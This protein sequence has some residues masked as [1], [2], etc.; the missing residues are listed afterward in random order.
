MV[1]DGARGHDRAGH[2]SAWRGRGG[3]DGILNLEVDDAAAAWARLRDAGA[4]VLLALRDEPF[5]QRHFILEGPGGVMV[6]V[7][8]NMSAGAGIRRGVHAGMRARM[9]AT[10]RSFPAPTSTRPARH[11]GHALRRH[12]TETRRIMDRDRRASARRAPRPTR[13]GAAWAV[14]RARWDVAV[15]SASERALAAAVLLDAASYPTPVVRA[16][17][18]VAR[19]GVIQAITAPPLP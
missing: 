12:S 10:T 19:R 1:A 9:R 6:D 16:A 2:G 4:P 11:P 5:G 14:V 18:A 3:C 15:G 13:D 8:E 7:I 17:A